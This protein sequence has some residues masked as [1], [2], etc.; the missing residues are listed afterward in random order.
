M[1]KKKFFIKEDDGIYTVTNDFFNDIERRDEALM[2]AIRIID[3]IHITLKEEVLEDDEML[4]GSIKV[5]TGLQR[6]LDELE[7]RW[8]NLLNQM[9][10]TP[11]RV[12]GHTITFN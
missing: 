9:Y 10:S 1:A 7:K 11:R 3:E 8:P 5:T 6:S 12:D 4:I 2:I